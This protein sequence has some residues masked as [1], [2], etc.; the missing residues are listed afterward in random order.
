MRLPEAWRVQVA[1][2]DELLSPTQMILPETPEMYRRARLPQIVLPAGRS[3]AGGVF[4]AGVG[5]V[6]GARRLFAGDTQRLVA[7]RRASRV[8]AAYW[9]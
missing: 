6:G 1:L 5:G 2:V 8:T 4:V 7:E 9:K 3:S